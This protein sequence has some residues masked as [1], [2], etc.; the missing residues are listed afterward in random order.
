[1]VYGRRPRLS[2]NDISFVPANEP[3]DIPPTSN[4]KQYV[5]Q[6]QNNLNHMRFH[7]LDQA[8]EHKDAFH[9]RLVDGT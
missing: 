2:V 1:M 5:Q 6:L 3:T 9:A 4:H 7:A 8:I